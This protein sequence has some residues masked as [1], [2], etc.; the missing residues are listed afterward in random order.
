MHTTPIDNFDAQKPKAPTKP[1][2]KYPKHPPNP[3]LSI[4]TLDP[5]KLQASDFLDLA[6]TSGGVRIA[7]PNATFNYLEF[8]HR[9]PTVNGIKGT[10]KAISFPRVARGFLYFR[11]APPG[12]PLAA[13]ELRFRK[14]ASD[15]PEAFA[16]GED[17][18]VGDRTWRLTFRKIFHGRNLGLKGLVLSGGLE[19]T[20]AWK[21]YEKV[22]SPV[23]LVVL[24][25]AQ[26][27]WKL[28]RNSGRKF[29]RQPMC[30]SRLTP[31]RLWILLNCCPQI[32]STCRGSRPLRLA[33]KAR[34]SSSRTSS[35]VSR[36]TP[37]GSS[38]TTRRPARRI[39]TGP[40][41]S[42]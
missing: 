33:S 18:K 14:T 2:P 34:R 21:A 3:P 28:D 8:T 9:V 36:I 5:A 1:K 30:P 13:G 17:L 16:E 4:Q 31:C 25:V 42:A 38:T 19:E 39:S 15:R 37:A 32:G 7:M 6:K 24:L 10:P 29:T 12:E 11:P 35:A 23:W 41:A 22:A 27:V 20:E 40:F 26:R